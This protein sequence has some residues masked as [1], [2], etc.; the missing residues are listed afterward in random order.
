MGKAPREIFTRMLYLFGKAEGKMG[1][2]GCN[3]SPFLIKP[4]SEIQQ[5]SLLGKHTENS[6]LC[7]NSNIL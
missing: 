4:P 5:C 3:F 2:N 7:E 6:L 1:K